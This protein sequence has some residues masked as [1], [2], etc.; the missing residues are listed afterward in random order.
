MEA[1]RTEE[2]LMTPNRQK[3]ETRS[4]TLAAEE[5]YRQHHEHIFRF[6]WSRVYDAQ[7]AEDLTGEVFTRMVANLSGFRDRSLPFRAWLYRIARN[8]IIDHQRKESSAAS[9]ADVVDHPIAQASPEEQAEATLTLK[10]VQRALQ[11]IDPEQREVVEL[12]FLGELS[13]EE[14]S[15]VL[16]KSIP[17]VKALQH[18]G[19]A[20][21]RAHLKEFK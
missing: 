6:I 21:L 3:A 2:T 16:N 19:L 18:R 5:L 13:L 11:N 20:S 14:V 8:L 10:Q 4:Q 1:V 12:R 7:Q 9:L 15:L 17:A